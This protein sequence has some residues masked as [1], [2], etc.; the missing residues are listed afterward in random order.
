MITLKK[1][2][3]IFLRAQAGWFLSNLTWASFQCI[4]QDV[5]RNN[6]LAIQAVLS[7]QE[8]SAYTYVRHTHK[9][10]QSEMDENGE[11]YDLQKSKHKQ[12]LYSY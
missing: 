3:N 2:I 7:R 5:P 8:K 4:G 9:L 12:E 11:R 10:Q 6:M 1:S